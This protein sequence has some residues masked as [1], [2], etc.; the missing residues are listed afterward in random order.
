MMRT[1]SLAL[2]VLLA[3]P[4]TALAAPQSFNTALPVSEGQ[5]LLRGQG[6]VGEFNTV[7]G[8]ELSVRGGLGVVAYGVTSDLTVF[9]A[10]PYWFRN[11]SG[12]GDAAVRE[13]DGIG[14]LRLFAR[15]TFWQRDGHGSTLRLAGF[16]GAELPSGA[17]RRSDSEGLLPPPVQ[18][19]SGSIDPFFGSTLT[20]QSL[21]VVFDAQLAWQ[22]NTRRGGFAAGDR[23]QADISAQYRLLPRELGG[24][25]P[26]FLYGGLEVNFLAESDRVATGAPLPATDRRRLLLSPGLQYVTRRYVLEAQLQLPVWQTGGSNRLRED[27]TLRAGFRIN[28]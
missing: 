7:D 20:W 21:D 23:F 8:G 15:Y 25:V 5:W 4:G 11:L 22:E 6:I 9:A 13:T 16:A 28:F 18:P 19:G 14:D 26:G 17:H 2:C 24:G 27:F 1:H 3:M 10:L 12:P